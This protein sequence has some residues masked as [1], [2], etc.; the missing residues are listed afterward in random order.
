VLPKAVPELHEQ[1]VNQVKAIFED[2]LAI[3]DIDMSINFGYN[4]VNII[5]KAI[6]DFYL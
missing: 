4:R 6:S 5:N 3:L 2:F 1:S